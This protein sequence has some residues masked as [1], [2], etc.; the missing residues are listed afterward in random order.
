MLV[1][2]SCCIFEITSLL[3]SSA[4]ERL[5]HREDNFQQSQCPL[6][7]Y[8]AMMTWN[9]SME[10][11]A[12][13]TGNGKISWTVHSAAACF[14]DSELFVR[15]NLLT[16]WYLKQLGRSIMISFAGMLYCASSSHD[17]QIDCLLHVSRSHKPGKPSCR[18]MTGNTLIL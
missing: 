11:K 8:L 12:H 5:N 4:L 9:P 2:V 3:P 18:F 15:A 13:S 10:S 7:T 16:R 6:A 14:G 17:F 1:Q